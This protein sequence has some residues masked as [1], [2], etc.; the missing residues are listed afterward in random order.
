MSKTVGEIMQDC[1]LTILSKADGRETKSH[2]SGKIEITA[3][4]IRLAYAE[5]NAFVTITLQDSRAKVRREG[6]YALALDLQK[7]KT[8]EGELGLGGSSGTIRTKTRQIF[9]TLK[10]K[11]LLLTLQYDLLFGDDAQAMSLR[12]RANF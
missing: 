12:I 11:S 3:E 10:E 4:E 8:C 7:G 6:D 2:R 9:Y 1:T 5:E